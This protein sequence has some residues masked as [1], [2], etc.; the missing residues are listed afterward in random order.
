MEKVG[1]PSIRLSGKTSPQ[2][3]DF[4]TT[5]LLSAIDHKDCSWMLRLAFTNVFLGFVE[6]PA[7]QEIL[8]EKVGSCAWAGKVCLQHSVAPEIRVVLRE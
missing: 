5:V 6:N 3:E 8:E 2:R 1:F 7:S 4:E